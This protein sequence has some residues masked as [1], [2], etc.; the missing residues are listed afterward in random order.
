[1]T[2]EPRL[3]MTTA[4]EL[5]RLG[6][7]ARHALPHLVESTLVPLALFYGFL[8]LVGIW[9]ALVVALGWSWV[10]VARR[11]LLRRP[12]PGLLLLGTVG[13]TARTVVAFASGSVLVYFLQPTLT[14]V[15]IAGA[16]L[17]SVPAGRPLAER[18]AAD[19]LPIPPELLRRPCVRKVFVR[20]TVLWAG[21]NL[22]NV[23]A[24][25]AL[26][27]LAPLA[28]YP[29]TK[30]AV[31]AAVA[32]VAVALSTRWFRQTLR[33]HDLVVASVPSVMV[34]LGPSVPGR[35]R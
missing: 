35:R 30:T 21:V 14:T 13:L 9:T 3:P 16:F 33:R 26:L 17:L 32:A 7:L 10:A 28:A 8:W 34:A 4:L 25:L 18:L 22:F 27:L 11:V 19:F 12:V 29:L 2:D 23:A 20:I 31:S 24:S 15:V 5:P 1:M 6:T